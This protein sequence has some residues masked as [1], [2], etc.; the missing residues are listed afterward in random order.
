MINILDFIVLDNVIASYKLPCILDLKMGTQI[1]Y[2]GDSEGKK[3]RHEEKSSRTT[4]KS[5]GLRLQGLQLYNSS[6][7]SWSYK[8]KYHGRDFDNQKLIETVQK[9]INEAPQPIRNNIAQVI[10]IKLYELRLVFYKKNTLSAI[11][12]ADFKLVSQEIRII[13]F[14][15]MFLMI[16]ILN[17]LIK[18]EKFDFSD[19]LQ[20][21]SEISHS[22]SVD[23]FSRFECVRAMT[24]SH[25]RVRI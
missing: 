8:N 18:I 24:H 3:R 23:Y 25:S 20:I 4:S 19:F 21:Q 11:D 5:M 22:G 12:W 17:D 9:F 1:W 16:F 14:F 2:P 15:E 10:K 6:K 13:N 7:S